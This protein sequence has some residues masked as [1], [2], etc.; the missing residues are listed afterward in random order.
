MPDEPRHFPPVGEHHG[1]KVQV[2]A[3]FDAI[4]PRYDLLNRVL[5]AGIDQRWRDRL[6]ALAGTQ[7]PRRIL[8]VATGTA[9]VA[10]KAARLRPER[11][12][13]VDISERMLEIGRE[14]VERAGLSHLIRLQQADSTRLPFSDRQ[15]DAVTVA[16]GVRNFEDLDLGLAEMRR[17][18][19]DGGVAAILEFS[20]P[21][22][23]PIKQFYRFY[24]RRL[25]PLIGTLVSRDRGAYHYLP[26]SVAAFPFG[27]EFA[28]RMRAAGYVD[29]TY[30]ALTF[31][32]ATIYVGRR[33][34]TDTAAG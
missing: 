2:E 10:I 12:V 29:V 18:L 24:S 31:G 23:F 19:R 13:G 17:V 16:F 15:F 26:E 4:A 34:G 30:E 6:I 8:D 1:K 3:M 25:L 5:S 33:S 20:Q 7:Q 27:E 21:T 11:I 22:A 14:K 28:G 9:D 32:I